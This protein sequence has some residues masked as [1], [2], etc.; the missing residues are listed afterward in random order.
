MTPRYFR[1][2]GRSPMVGPGRSRPTS[3]ERIMT[4]PGLA[5][6]ATGLRIGLIV[7]GGLVGLL[8]LLAVVRPEMMG[9]AMI[10]NLFVG[11]GL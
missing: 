1:A 8:L 10:R 6:I 4:K 9:M 7:A 5:P 2:A 3:T 11:F